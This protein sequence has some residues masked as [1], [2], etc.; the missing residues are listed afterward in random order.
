MRRFKVG[1]LIKFK[2]YPD[3]VG[4]IKRIYKDRHGVKY[5]V[6]CPHG[7]SMYTWYHSQVESAL[8]EELADV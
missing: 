1:Q 5:R 4:R 3:Y 7:Y 2:G 6:W 8:L